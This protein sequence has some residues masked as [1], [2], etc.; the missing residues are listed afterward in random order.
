MQ[1]FTHNRYA[2]Q[3]PATWVGRHW[4]STSRDG[5]GRYLRGLILDVR[6]GGVHVEWPPSEGR[7]ASTGWTAIDRGTLT[8]E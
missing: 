2:E 6:P 5:T 3:P 8:R 4:L 7:V 1:N